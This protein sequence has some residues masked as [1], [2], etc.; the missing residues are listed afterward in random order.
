MKGTRYRTRC[1][2][3]SRIAVYPDWLL[4]PNVGSHELRGFRQPSITRN[5]ATGTVSITG[6]PSGPI[7]VWPPTVTSRV[8]F[9][10]KCSTSPGTQ[11][12]AGTSPR[13]VSD[14]CPISRVS[15]CRVTT[16]CTSRLWVRFRTLNGS[17]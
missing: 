16:T 5:V 6:W 1:V 4:P 17:L 7:T 12:S 2:V 10:T 3:L 11:T 9:S 14:A 15:W 8:T 13:I